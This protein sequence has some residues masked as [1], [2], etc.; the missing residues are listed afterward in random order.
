[1][2][3]SIIQKR[4]T[5]IIFAIYLVLLTWL[6]LFKFA[7]SISDLPSIRGINLIPF[8]YE[9]E[10][11]TYTHVKEVVYNIL[12]FIPLGVYLQ[13]LKSDWKM[14]TKCLTV[15]GCSLLLE[16]IQFLFAIGASDITDV[17]G[18]TAGG[19][20]GILFCIVWSKIAPKKGVFVINGVGI[21][22]EMAAMGLLMLL[23][24]VNR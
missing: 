23:M 13:I 20:I 11:S 10:I 1:M 22:I 24:V 2:F 15:L 9:H 7:I 19:I 3:Q 18:N 17:I 4:M 5:W 6:V 21:L 8:Y 14:A 16:I 12:V